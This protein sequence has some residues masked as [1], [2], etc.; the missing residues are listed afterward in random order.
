MESGGMLGGD[1]EI[2]GVRSVKRYQ[3]GAIGQNEVGKKEEEK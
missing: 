1:R 3:R 2:W